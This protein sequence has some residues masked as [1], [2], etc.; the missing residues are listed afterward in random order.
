MHPCSRCRSSD[1][2]KKCKVLFEDGDCAECVCSGK[3][4]D[5][6]IPDSVCLCNPFAN[7]DRFFLTTFLVKR[8]DSAKSKIKTQLEAS[9]RDVTQRQESAISL[10]SELCRQHHSLTLALSKQKRLSEIWNSLQHR[11]DDLV[12]QEV[13]TLRQLDEL[14]SNLGEAED[15]SAVDIPGNQLSLVQEGETSSILNVFDPSFDFDS[16]MASQ[17]PLLT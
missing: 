8:I 11:E 10:Q 4:C 9:A 2:P 16:F 6:F 1:P 14:D 5:V 17:E 12:K 7:F 3:K 13:R 15:P